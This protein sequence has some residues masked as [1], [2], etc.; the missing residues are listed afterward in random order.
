MESAERVFLQ[1][2]SASAPSSRI[3]H[4]L[5][6]ACGALLREACNGPPEAWHGDLLDLVRVIR[7]DACRAVLRRVV[8][9]GRFDAEH[10][11]LK[12]D[13]RWLH[14]A[15]EYRWDPAAVVAAW[16]RLL[17]D[18]QYNVIAYRALAHDLELGIWYLPDL[19]DAVAEPQRS[20]VL[21]QAMRLLLSHAQS[22]WASRLRWRHGHLAKRQGLCEAVDA[23]L[24]QLNRPPVFQTAQGP[25]LQTAP[26]RQGVAEGSDNGSAKL[27]KI[28]QVRAA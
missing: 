1:L 19:Y 18:P 28:A 10:V 9:E 13:R 8:E 6:A 3:R 25:A 21:R 14:A 7:P 5:G 26:R 2:W 20:F 4:G 22:D 23:A 15:A 27:R 11:N 16:K 12:L 24:R 17:R